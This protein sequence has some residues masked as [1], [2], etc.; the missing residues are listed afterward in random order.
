MATGFTGDFARLVPSNH[1]AQLLFSKTYVYVE[2]NDTFHLRFMESIGSE[3]LLESA[4][5]VES[6]TDYD[7]N[8]ETNK[9]DSKLQTLG[10]FVL[11]FDEGRSPAMPHLGWRV[12]RGS[13]K[14]TI[15]RNVDLL[16]AKPGDNRSKSLA[17]IHMLFRF[18]RKSGF[19][20]L[21][22]ASPKVPV[23]YSIGGSWRQLGYEKEKLLY[24]VSTM[25]RAGMCEYKLEY[26][27]EERHRDAYF[28]HRNIFLKMI[29]SNKGNL[30]R[31]FQ[32]M[33]GDSCVLRGRYLEFETKGFGAFGWITQGI[34]TETGDPVAIKELRINGRRSRLEIMSEVNMGIRFHVSKV[35]T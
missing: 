15:N 10:H 34:D 32:K 17:S 8:S 13:S 9:E 29:P 26:T 25:L 21:R 3:A 16:L 22:G 4:E 1:I 30:P 35:T 2:K 20:M 5:P 12:G 18:S 31:A 24:Q 6:S 11:S 19:L 33:P 14:G 7:T 27:I 23:E 28:Q